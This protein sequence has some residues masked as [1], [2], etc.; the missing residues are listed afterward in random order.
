MAKA[1]AVIKL[2]RISIENNRISDCLSRW[3]EADNTEQFRILTQGYEVMFRE[4]ENM[5]KFSHDW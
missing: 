2:V 4:I 1:N 3:G 5:F